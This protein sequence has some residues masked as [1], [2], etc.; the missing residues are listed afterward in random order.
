MLLALTPL[1]K[2]IPVIFAVCGVANKDRDDRRVHLSPALSA[3]LARNDT[4]SRKLL[5][6]MDRKEA[7]SLLT[8]FTLSESLRKHALAV[9]A[10]VRAYARK[11]GGDE[12]LWGVVG[13][14]HDFDY[15]KYPSLDDHPYKGS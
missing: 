7:W 10:C 6:T 8:E 14:I 13:L 2:L 9:E 4:T 11:F 5:K 15:E 1:G 12:D 3:N